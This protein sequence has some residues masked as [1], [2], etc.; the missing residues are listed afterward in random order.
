[1]IDLLK[2][3]FRYQHEH[4]TGEP[5]YTL[6]EA[7]ERYLSHCKDI[8]GLSSYTIKAYRIDL[9]QLMECLG[10]NVLLK[11]IDKHSISK[12]L[13]Y[14]TQNQLKPTSIKRK[15]ACAK[16][17]FSWLE[18]EEHIDASPFHKFVLNLKLPKHLPRNIAKSDLK[19]ILNQA[20]SSTNTGED[21]K[22][23][24]IDKHIQNGKGL[25]HFTALVVVELL[26]TTGVRV[27][28]L[29]GIKL[30]DVSLP[31]KKIKI[32]GK[33]SR[34][35]FVYI[36]DNELCTLIR[37][38]IELRHV[39]EPQHDNF[40]VNSRGKP[41]STQFT[42]KLVRN[43]SNQTNS[44][45]KATPHMFRHSAAC[46]FLAAGVDMRYVQ[47]LLG[48]SSISTT[49]IYTHVSDTLLQQKLQK[50]NLRSAIMKK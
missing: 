47:K 28:E 27:G 13:D 8:R 6:I 15:L 46:E 43:I 38:Y 36:L 7:T 41:A 19:S 9:R 37:R 50:S 49:E 11:D 25:N 10:I 18:I 17:M 30:D 22:Q 33:G 5:M 1:M 14:L 44:N 2:G 16:A 31:E 45:L 24:F 34:E 21:R 29:A 4:K 40:L 3:H 48:H 42:R 39:V 23:P 26:V 35:R 32:M 20:R 12:F